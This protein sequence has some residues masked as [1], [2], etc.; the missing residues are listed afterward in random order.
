MKRLILTHA[1]L[2]QLKSAGP[3]ERDDALRSLMYHYYS[4]FYRYAKGRKLSDDD[5]ESAVDDTWFKIDRSRE[6]YCGQICTCQQ[7][8]ECVE[9]AAQGYVWK[10]CKN[11]VIDWLRKGKGVEAQEM[12]GEIYP[13]HETKFNSPEMCLEA[14]GI[15][16]AAL[17][18]FKSLSLA[19]QQLLAEESRRGRPNKTREQAR[20]EARDR[21]RQAFRSFLDKEE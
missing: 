11:C 21:F 15:Q 3:R 18:A 7:D 4:P 5:A 13:A 16:K 17:L 19:D 14:N 2:M 20:S 10:I 8:C 12:P 1:L 9:L 6:K